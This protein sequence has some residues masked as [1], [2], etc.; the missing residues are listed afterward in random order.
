MND[1]VFLQAFDAD[2]AM[3]TARKFED[4]RFAMSSVMSADWRERAAGL[5]YLVKSHLKSG[6]ER[7][8]LC[9]NMLNDSD[10]RVRT[11]AIALLPHCRTLIDK[12]GSDIAALLVEI[13]NDASRS[14]QEQTCARKAMI[15]LNAAETPTG[16]E[17]LVDNCEI[18]I[19]RHN[20]FML[21]NKEVENTPAAPPKNE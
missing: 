13:A 6:H 8:A 19:S 10:L 16:I 12:G 9:K 15:L 5:E 3:R 7:L 4:S 1:F 21:D 18:I 11:F 17:A 20:D 2:F 14:L